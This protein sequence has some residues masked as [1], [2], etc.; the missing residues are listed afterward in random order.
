MTRLDLDTEQTYNMQNFKDS[1]DRID[2][3]SCTWLLPLVFLQ[4]SCFSNTGLEHSR[5]DL[6]LK[7]SRLCNDFIFGMLYSS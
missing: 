6:V 5:S 3:I 4:G 1:T 7:H 2:T